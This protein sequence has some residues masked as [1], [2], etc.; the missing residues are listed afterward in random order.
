MQPW[1]ALLLT[2]AASPFAHAFPRNH[3]NSGKKHNPGSGG[4][5]T[6]TS[7]TPPSPSS[8]SGSST[9]TS[10]DCS[11]NTGQDSLLYSGP[12]TYVLA[13]TLKA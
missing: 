9:S 3:P 6:T 5:S 11:A 10:I 13:T 4:S 12:Y 7:S 1:F 8:S 2:L